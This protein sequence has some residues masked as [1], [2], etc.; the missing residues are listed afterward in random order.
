MDGYNRSMPTSPEV[1]PLVERPWG[2]YRKLF[3]EHGVWVKRVEV[4]P[5]GRLSLQKHSYRSEKWN[6]VIGNGIVHLDGKVADVRSG[7]IID[8]PVGMVHR[9]GNTGTTPLI[10]IEVAV[11]VNGGDLSEDDILRIE[12]DYN[13]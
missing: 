12:D 4:Y 7:A 10:F 3:E 5:G 6:I 11:A 13:R 1:F 9:I 8:V 2:H